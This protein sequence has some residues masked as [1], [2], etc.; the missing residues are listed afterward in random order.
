MSQDNLIK[1]KSSSGTLVYTRKNR[2]KLANHKI[3]LKKYDPK[4]R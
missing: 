3:E 1:M 2:K 4:L